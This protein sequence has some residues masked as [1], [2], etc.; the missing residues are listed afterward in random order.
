MKATFAALLIF[1]VVQ[2]MKGDL[3]LNLIAFSDLIRRF[4][5]IFVTFLRWFWYQ[6]VISK[7]SYHI[8][9]KQ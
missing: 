9:L 4:L 5:L 7:N 1:L 6:E 3:K 2:I 8:C